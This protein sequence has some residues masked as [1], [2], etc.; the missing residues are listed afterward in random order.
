MTRPIAITPEQYFRR[1]HEFEPTACQIKIMDAMDSCRF[2]IIDSN[3][4]MMGIS[5]AI[6]T[7][8][9]WE[10]LYSN[11]AISIESFGYPIPN[12]LSRIDRSMEQYRRD[13]SSFRSRLGTTL[14]QSRIEYITS[15]RYRG[16]FPKDVYIID[17]ASID[18]GKYRQGFYNLIQESKAQIGRRLAVVSSPTDYAMRYDEELYPTQYRTFDGSRFVITTNRPNELA[19]LLLQ[20]SEDGDQVAIVIPTIK[21]KINFVR[22]VIPGVIAADI[23]GVQPMTTHI[24]NIFT[25]SI[26]Y[27]TNTQ[28][29]AIITPLP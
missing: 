3:E 6:N 16:T 20:N 26:P 4:R 13:T 22:R 18:E 12:D 11:E 10:F 25:L 7:Y 29:S 15:D 21:P 5:T 23:T 8:I 17:D 28:K 2:T 14:E 1:Q 24:G 9:T 27:Y 19:K